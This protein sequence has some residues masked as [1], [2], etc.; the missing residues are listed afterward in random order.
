MAADDKVDNLSSRTHW[1]SH[2]FT[3]ISVRHEYFCWRLFVKWN[4]H[5]LLWFSLR[6]TTQVFSQWPYTHYLFCQIG[7]STYS[8]L[9]LS[10]SQITDPYLHYHQ[11]QGELHQRKGFFLH[12][13]DT[14][15]QMFDII[16]KLASLDFCRYIFLFWILFTSRLGFK[17]LFSFQWQYFLKFSGFFFC[18]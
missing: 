10:L 1:E 13:H 11:C 4:L 8:L 5:A 7:G 16:F 15:I 2:I 9:S 18:C 14:T 12:A 17:L 6:L 3:I